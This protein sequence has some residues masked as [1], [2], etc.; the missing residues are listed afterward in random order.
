MNLDRRSIELRKLIIKMMR[1]DGR[2]HLGPAFSLV[3]IMRVLYDSVLNIDPKFCSSEDRDKFILSKGHGCLA[4]YAILAD[5]NFFPVDLLD[6][7]CLP[8]SLLGGHPEKGR[9]PGIEASTGSL[10]HGPSIGVGMA[11]AA[12]I[13]NRANKVYV[14]I[15]DGEMNEGSVWEAAMSAA[16]HKLSNLTL[17]IDRNSLQSYGATSEVLDMSPLREK[18][19]SFGFNVLEVDGHDISALKSAF[20]NTNTNILMPNIIIC[21]TIKGFGL[22]FAEGNPE[23]HHKSNIKQEE[24]ENMLNSLE[25]DNA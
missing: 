24:F 14:L 25:K 10:G 11:L 23:W 8:N 15:G 22:S 9:L 16:K 6:T 13:R 19:L 18:W 3:E 7:F 12:R 1:V 5:K 20:L 2:G 21:N 17:I 4:L